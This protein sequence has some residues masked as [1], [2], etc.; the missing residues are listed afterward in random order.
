MGLGQNI[1]AL[2]EIRDISQSELAKRVGV[3]PQTIQ[4]LVSGRTKKTAYLAQ[5]AAV[6]GCRPMDLLADNFDATSIEESDLPALYA[7]DLGAGLVDIARVEYASIGR[8]DAALSAGPGSLLEAEPEPMG[9]H[10]VE[11]QWLRTVTRATPNHLAIVR[12]DG[13][14]MEPTFDDGDWV[15]IDATQKRLSRQ[16]VYAFRVMDAL[17]VKRIEINLQNRLIHITSDNRN[18]DPQD[19][20][21]DELDVLGRVVCIVARKV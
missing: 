11:A 2:L 3:K 20:A 21:E 10:L 9:Y 19:L 1:A 5:I 6:L 18:Y 8:Y 4:S 7:G 16:G 12:V 17:W 14:S 13:D 15:M